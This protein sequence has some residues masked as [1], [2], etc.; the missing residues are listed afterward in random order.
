MSVGVT[1]AASLA[2]SIFLTVRRRRRTPVDAAARAFALF[3]NRLR[4]LAVAPLAPGEGPATYGDRAQ[5]ALPHAAI[6]IAAIVAAYL[7]A[8]YEPDP[9][10][11]ALTELQ[12][13]VTGFRPART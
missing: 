7:R 12:A 6:D 8:R 11:A 1:L 13:R 5:R 9:N 2:L 4:R 3:S 10:H